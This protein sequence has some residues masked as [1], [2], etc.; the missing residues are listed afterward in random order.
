[1]VNRYQYQDVAWIDC[2]SPTEEE[3]IDLADEFGLGSIL[4]QELM[5]PTPKP[6]VDLYPEFAYTVLHFPALR[7]THGEYPLQEV[8]IVMGKSFIITVHYG[9]VPAIYDFARSF[10][11]AILLRRS[12]GAALHT[13]HVLL[14]LTERLYQGV[15]NEL[16]S[17]EDE[18]S[19]IEKK[20]FSGHE[21]EMVMAISSVSRE[22]LNQKRSLATHHDILESFEQIGISLFGENLGN[23]FRAVAA[24]HYRVYHHA[25]ALS[26]TVDELH[27]TNDSLLTTSQNEVMKTLTIMA[28][29]TL[30]LTL[31]TGLFG[32]N[33]HYTPVLG[34]PNDFWIILAIMAILA[35]SFF[36]YFKHKKWF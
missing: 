28:F 13:G 19:M 2:E 32:M 27:R 3:I 10:E 33:T 9:P 30:P 35:V 18:V 26:D 21:R 36:L 12:K 25:L 5:T 14:E 1:M 17:L 6:R 29:I 16:E 20:I 15:E 8:D 7:Q 11:A 4:S 34:V 23:Y 22:L 24:F 31:I